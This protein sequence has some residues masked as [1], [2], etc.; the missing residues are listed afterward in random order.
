MPGSPRVPP[1][2]WRAS[3]RAR[4]TRSPSHRATALRLLEE[5]VRWTAFG[6]A[7]T[8][9]ASMSRTLPRSD[10]RRDQSFDADAAS[11]EVRAGAGEADCSRGRDDGRVASRSFNNAA[12]A[13]CSVWIFSRDETTGRGALEDAPTPASSSRSSFA[14]SPDARA[15][16]DPSVRAPPSA[17]RRPSETS[18]ADC[19]CADGEGLRSEM[20]CPR[21]SRQRQFERRAGLGRGRRRRVE[22]AA[23]PDS[24]AGPPTARFNVIGSVLLEDFGSS[25]ASQASPRPT[26]RR[27][28]N[29]ANHATTLG[30]IRSPFARLFER[31]R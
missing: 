19:E 17:R 22:A 23:C 6:R 11:C 2:T 20:M 25:T 21:H 18:A 7:R 4:R 10:A 1:P 30:A 26:F 15:R 8:A 28:G 5:R 3:A 31:A 24:T 13:A 14:S 27:F 16:C 12:R 29:G 9:S